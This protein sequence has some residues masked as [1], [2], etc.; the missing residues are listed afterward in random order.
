[1]SDLRLPPPPIFG[2][3]N[4][5]GDRLGQPG[6]MMSL[7]NIFD[8]FLFGSDKMPNVH[9]DG[10]TTSRQSSASDDFDDDKDDDD[11]DFSEDGDSTDGK[12]RKRRGQQRYMTEEQ[13]VERR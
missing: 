11:D 4:A 2:V 6:G 1:M 5:D 12:K 7:D 8:D 13:K 9:A 3:A 10:S